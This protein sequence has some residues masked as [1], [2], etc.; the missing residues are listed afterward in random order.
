MAFLKRCGSCQRLEV[1]QASS[2]LC[3]HH[4]APDDERGCKVA[5][6]FIV[7]R[8]ALTAAAVEGGTARQAEE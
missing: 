1:Q 6:Y 5:E 8:A 7:M 2:N 3:C 4:G